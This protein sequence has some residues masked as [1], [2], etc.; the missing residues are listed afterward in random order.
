MKRTK[1]F[2][3]VGFMLL[4]LS[5]VLFAGCSS[6]SDDDPPQGE[7]VKPIYDI[8]VYN[9]NG[10]E[11]N[12]DNI[13]FTM[14]GR[15]L[16]EGETFIAL[17]LTGAQVKVTNNKLTVNLGT[18]PVAEGKLIDMTEDGVTINPP[19]ARFYQIN[20]FRNNFGKK[21]HLWR[22]EGEVKHIA[23]LIYATEA[24]RVSFQGLNLNV[25][26]GWNWQFTQEEGGFPYV[27]NNPMAFGFKWYIDSMPSD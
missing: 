16:G 23:S 11:Y 12:G 13:T 6:S 14:M 19:S 5:G 15:W 24:S 4:A 1:S 8:T 17:G 22:K 20:E 18:Q 3:R 2:L 9:A 7:P 10:D 26:K 21:L 25:S 27:G